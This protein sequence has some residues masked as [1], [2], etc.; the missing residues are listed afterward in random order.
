MAAWAD[1][2]GD[3][4][5]VNK[6]SRIRA[7]FRVLLQISA[8]SVSAPAAVS[9]RHAAGFAVHSGDLP[10]SDR[11]FRRRH[12]RA[13]THRRLAAVG[14]Y[15]ADNAA[16]TSAIKSALSQYD[17]RADCQVDLQGRLGFHF[18]Q[19]FFYGLSPG[20]TLFGDNSAS[21]MLP[22]RTAKLPFG[23]A[24]GGLRARIRSYG[25]GVA[26]HRLGARRV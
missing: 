8:I 1:R 18:R 7:S 16:R 5:A 14:F 9:A 19:H 10:V 2:F 17:S 3:V 13:S 6:L 11:K 26:G 20:S 12:P 25:G 4:N 24:T 21:A 22:T 23:P 15:V